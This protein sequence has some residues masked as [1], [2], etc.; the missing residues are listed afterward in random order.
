MAEKEVG[1][2]FV[3]G[4]SWDTTERTLERAFSEYGKVIE[5]QVVLE[6][7]TGRSRGFGFVTFSEPRAVDAAIRGMH[8][9]ELDGR[10]ISVNKAQPRMNTDDG[11]GYGGGGGGG[12]TYSSGARGGYRGGGDAV[13]SANDDCFKCGRAGHWARECPY[14]SGG[15]GGRTGR[16]SPPSRYGSGTGGGRGDRFGGS[17]RFANR[18]VD[19]RYDGGRYVDDRYGGGGRDRYATDRYPP[20]ADRFTGDRY[21]GSDRYASSGFTRERSYERDGGRSGGSYYRDEPRGSGGY[22]RGGMR[23]GSGD[24]YGTGGPARFAGSYRDR[25]APYDR[26]SRAAART[27]DDRY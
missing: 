16:Y 19:D 10:T 24:R 21:G 27:Y 7:D 6:R 13:P 9:G 12:G 20:T 5:T 23:M 22:D 17:D 25:P 26:P 1:R 11:Y 4:L 2:I 3:G 14:S 8:N 15:G 18:Y